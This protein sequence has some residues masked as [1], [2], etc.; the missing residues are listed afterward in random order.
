MKKL[1]LRNAQRLNHS[2]EVEFGSYSQL[3]YPQRFGDKLTVEINV[4]QEDFWRASLVT[5]R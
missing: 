3:D 5:Q 1:R 2:L 4:D